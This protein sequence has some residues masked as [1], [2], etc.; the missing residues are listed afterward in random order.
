MSAWKGG[1]IFGKLSE[2]KKPLHLPNTVLRPG[3]AP[4]L[5]P[6]AS[7]REQAWVISP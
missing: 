1:K 3:S 2:L 6:K 5:L 7:R 4:V